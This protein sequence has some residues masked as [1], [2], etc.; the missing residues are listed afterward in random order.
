[1]SRPV[2][3]EQLRQAWADG[4]IVPLAAAE[5]Q[6][7]LAAALAATGC[8][9]T[10]PVLESLRECFGPGVVVGSG[11]SSGR[12]RWCLQPL[13]HLEASALATGRWLAA[14]GIDPG[15]CLHLNPLALHHVSGLL[16]LVR[17]RCWGCG[18]LPIQP[19]LLR[20][21]GALAAAVPLPS[22]RPILLS[23]VPTQLQRLMATAQGLAWLQRLTLI[24][25]GGAPLPRVV[26]AGARAA[27][28]R[29]A[30]CYGATETA[31][32]VCALEPERFLA[33]VDGCG[34][35][36]ADVELQ[37][38]PP[39]GAIAVRTPR[40]SPGCLEA[41]TLLPLPIS[42]EGWWASGDAGWLGAAGLTVLGRLDGAIH[43]GGETVFPEQVEQRLMAA[44]AAA[45]LPLQACLLLPEADPEWG[46][47]LVALVRPSAEA[48]G[49]AAALLHRLTRL[50]RGLPAAERPRRWLLCPELAPG[51]HGKWRRRHWQRWLASLQ[52]DQ[53]PESH[54]HPQRG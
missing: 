30:P 20:D 50:G 48:A 15:A 45:G 53:T 35:P 41:G 28:L 14:G 40:L 19:A 24:W 37:L 46:Q 47:R 9:G 29:L 32:M 51:S 6:A 34:G 27:G 42:G 54:D 21:P 31:A 38:Q 44:A 25:V 39:L 1:M 5:E 3:P 17:S 49:E 22:D 13:S 33:G 7:D 18:H 8:P 4:R 26:A 10:A 16:P 12:R 52:A 23:L 36:L 2:T 11:G 43:S